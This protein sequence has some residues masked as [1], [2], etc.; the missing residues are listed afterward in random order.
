MNGSDP[1]P[2]REA[3]A[4][5]LAGNLCRCTGYATILDSVLTAA[6]TLRVVE[7]QVDGVAR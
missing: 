3:V 4:E 1:A 6:G 5:G 2:S 7:P